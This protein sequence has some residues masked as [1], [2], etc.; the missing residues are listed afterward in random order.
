MAR[1]IFIT[2][3]DQEDVEV[4]YSGSGLERDTNA[5]DLDWH[6]TDPELKD[7]TVTPEEEDFI[8]NKCAEA[9]DNEGDDY[10]C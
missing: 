2:F 8:F 10:D 7:I 9:M 4:E 3:R 1:S 6:F 5:Y